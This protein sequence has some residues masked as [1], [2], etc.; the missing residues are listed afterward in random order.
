MNEQSVA[1]EKSVIDNI[2]TLFLASTCLDVQLVPDRHT[3]FIVCPLVLQILQNEVH[4][5]AETCIKK[6]KL[7]YCKFSVVTSS[8]IVAKKIDGVTN[9]RLQ[10][11]LRGKISMLPAFLCLQES[12]DRKCTSLCLSLQVS[13]VG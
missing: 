3:S 4:V 11:I 5:V 12:S 13:L 1:F 8:L 9:L 10:E 6:N 2:V 7:A